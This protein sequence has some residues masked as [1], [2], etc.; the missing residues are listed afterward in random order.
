[1]SILTTNVMLHMMK[2]VSRLFSCKNKD[3]KI[4]YSN[5]FCA[6]KTLAKNKTIKIAIKQY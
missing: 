5:V 6:N 2:I 3:F 4:L 1:M